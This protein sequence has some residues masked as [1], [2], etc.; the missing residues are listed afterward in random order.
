MVS[1]VSKYGNGF[2]EIA[3]FAT[4]L[5]RYPTPPCAKL[6]GLDILD[7]DPARGWVRVRFEAAADFRNASGAIQGGLLTAMLD[8]TMGP[9]VLIMTGARL[10]PTTIAMSVIFLAPAR[11]GELVGEATVLQLG[12]TIGFVEASLTDGAGVVIA[13]ATSSVRLRAMQSAD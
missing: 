10:Y 13:R 9:A 4:V 3:R 7:A 6:L 1:R 11:P 2:Q 8:D 12:K 5:D